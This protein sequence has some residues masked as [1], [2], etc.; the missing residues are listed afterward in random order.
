[1][2]S[3]H[4]INAN[5]ENARASTGPK[6]ARGRSRAARNAIRH[7]LTL[8]VYSD[9][10]L[11]EEVEAVARE[12][13]GTEANA[14]IKELARRVAE[15]QI[16]L[17]RVRYARHQLLSNALGDLYYESRAAARAK[18]KVLC[19]VLRPKAPEISMAAMTKFLTSTPQGPEKFSTILSE[20]AKRLL[21]MDR[22]ERRALFRRS[23]AIQ[24]FDE[25]RAYRLKLRA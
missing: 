1:L 7:G 4:R 5:R 3:G 25:A 17:R 10:A 15:A 24:A 8:P 21:A 18:F 16:D 22:Y 12:I 13:A 19:K 23:I 14:R 11:C 2:T 6:T 9:P 20:E